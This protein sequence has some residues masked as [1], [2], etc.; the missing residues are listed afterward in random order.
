M[1]IYRIKICLNLVSL[2]LFAITTNC[3]RPSFQ[4]ENELTGIWE[5]QGYG[6][7]VE[8]NDTTINLYDLT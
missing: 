3:N 2:I 6:E 5:M 1:N 8:I 4:D 7:I